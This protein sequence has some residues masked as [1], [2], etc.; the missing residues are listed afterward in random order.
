MTRRVQDAVG[1]GELQGTERYR[2]VAGA[3]V[4]WDTGVE[5]LVDTETIRVLDEDGDD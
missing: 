4:A 2:T 5:A 3:A 1:D